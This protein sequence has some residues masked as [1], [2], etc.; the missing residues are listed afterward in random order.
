MDVEMEVE[1][2]LKSFGTFYGRAII[3]LRVVKIPLVSCI[4]INRE[5]YYLIVWSMYMWIPKVVVTFNC[6]HSLYG[7]IPLPQCVLRRKK[8]LMRRTMNVV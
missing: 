8:L 4:N 3:L 2:M 6:S 1:S 5:L 7:I